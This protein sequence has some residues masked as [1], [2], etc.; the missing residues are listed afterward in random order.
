MFECFMGKLPNSTLLSLVLFIMM[1]KMVLTLIFDSWKE[2]N[3][4]I[5]F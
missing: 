1:Y 2:E 5:T 4:G 3:A